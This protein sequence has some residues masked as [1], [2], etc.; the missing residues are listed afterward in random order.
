MWA[1][2][3]AVM[4]LE[5]VARRP[6]ILPEEDFGRQLVALGVLLV[7]VTAGHAMAEGRDGG[8]V[9]RVGVKVFLGGG[10]GGVTQIRQA[11]RKRN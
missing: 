10:L 8:W 3:L 5:Q 9:Q 1:N 11:K 4:A 6:Q 2:V 7:A